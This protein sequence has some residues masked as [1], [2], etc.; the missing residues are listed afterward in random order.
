MKPDPANSRVLA[1]YKVGMLVWVWTASKGKC[2]L[3]CVN[4]NQRPDD[5]IKG[6]VEDKVGT[7]EGDPLYSVQLEGTDGPE[8]FESTRIRERK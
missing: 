5:W 7:T 2:T 3:Q 1:E 4:P 8:S 6:V